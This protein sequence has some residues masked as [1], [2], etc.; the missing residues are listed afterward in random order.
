[1]MATNGKVLDQ[2]IGMT[3]EELDLLRKVK[4]LGAASADELAIKMRRAG[5]D[6]QPEIDKLVER[7]LLQEQVIQ[8]DGGETR[9]YLTA[10]SVRPWL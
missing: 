7:H 3:Q 8:H 9:I 1:M 10:R 5:D 2:M 6:L 4:E